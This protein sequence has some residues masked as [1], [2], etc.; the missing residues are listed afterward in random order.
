MI[1]L[2]TAHLYPRLLKVD[3]NRGVSQ[4]CSPLGCPKTNWQGH[5]HH[6]NYA[7][8]SLSLEYAVSTTI[9]PQ[10]RSMPQGERR[11][12]VAKRGLGF[13]FIG[14]GVVVRR[15]RSALTPAAHAK[16]GS[17]KGGCSHSLH[18]YDPSRGRGQDARNGGSGVGREVRGVGVR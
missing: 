7:A 11:H 15:I 9:E 17:S 2:T 14:V 3:S 5:H 13:P 4:D 12:D 10:F 8:L 16:G 18:I 1:L 6:I